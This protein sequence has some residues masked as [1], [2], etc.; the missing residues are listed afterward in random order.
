MSSLKETESMN[1]T[2]IMK[3][4]GKIEEEIAEIK[5]FLMSKKTKSA[6]FKLGGILEGLEIDE[7][8]FSIATKS[9]FK[10]QDN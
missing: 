7:D 10:V 3:K 2:S 1:E 9:L 8:E 6:V 4:L 5:V